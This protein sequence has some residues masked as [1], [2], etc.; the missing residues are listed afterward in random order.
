L[1]ISKKNTEKTAAI[2][3]SSIHCNFAAAE[4]IIYSNVLIYKRGLAD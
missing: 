4:N 1:V 3:K 2:A